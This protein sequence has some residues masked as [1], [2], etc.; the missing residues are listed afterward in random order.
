MTKGELN[1]LFGRCRYYWS[2]NII[3]STAKK[4]YK[5]PKKEAKI[6]LEYRRSESNLGRSR[7]SG[8]VAPTPLQKF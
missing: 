6:K 5:K 8:I 1:I 7:E 2:V 3:L 4:V